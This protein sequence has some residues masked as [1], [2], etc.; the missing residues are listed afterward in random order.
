MLQLQ[1]PALKG[2]NILLGISGGIAA[3]K[4]PHL[5]RLLKAQGAN[6]RVITTEMAL[7]FVTAETL[8]V[9]SENPVISPFFDPEAKTWNNHVELGLWADAFVIAPC[10]SNTLAKLVNGQCDNLLTTAYLSARCPVWIAP[11]MDLDMYT[12]AS[13]QGNLQAFAEQEHQSIIEPNEGPLA[14]G[15]IGKGRMA[16]PEEITQ[17]LM[18]HFC[19]PHSAWAGK[20][21]MITAGPTHEAIDP[22]RFIGNRSSGR[23]GIELAK[24]LATQ[25]AVVHLILGP[26]HLEAPQWIQTHRVE[27]AADMHA[28]C[29]ELQGESDWIIMAAAVADYRPAQSADQKLKKSEKDWSLDLVPNAD[30]LKDLSKRRPE[31]QRIIGFALETQDAEAYGKTKLQTK[32]LDAI[33]IN[34]TGLH[35]GFGTETNQVL[36]LG[37][38]GQRHQTETEEKSR[39]AQTIID[40]LEEWFYA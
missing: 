39:I 22:V 31:G 3:Y 7:R 36:I 5:V 10:G 24:A 40:T 2:R 12:H 9:V 17:V 8:S 15:L 11:A 26:T 20:T 16:E 38:N 32:G 6:V 27:S 23:M 19:P 14:S 28:R 29:L 13:V 34:E 33:V 21:V 30:I 4:T 37:A 25:G 1:K 18:D 35:T